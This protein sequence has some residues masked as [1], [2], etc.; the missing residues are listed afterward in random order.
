MKAKRLD[1]IEMKRRAAL[2]IHERLKNMTV[3]QQIEYWRQ[4]S[5]GF[6]HQQEQRR[7]ERADDKTSR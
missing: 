4:R 1:C 2:R 6:Q 3:Q 5:E 7:A